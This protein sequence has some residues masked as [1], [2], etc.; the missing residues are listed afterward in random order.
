MA[1]ISKIRKNSW[2]LIVVIGLALAA[3][4]LMDMSSNSSRMSAKDQFTLGTVNGQT[5]DYREFQN[6]ENVLYSNGSGDIYGQRNYL[7]NYVKNKAI[8]NGE[9][10]VLGLGVG[11]PEL[12]E[13]Q[14]GNNLSPIIT[15][16]Y[17]DE[18]G[19]VSREQ[20]NGIR[21]AIQNG[22]FEPQ[23]KQFWAVQEQE[24]I[25]ERVQKK[26]QDMVSK[27][28][29]TPTWLAEWS[30][31]LKTATVDMEYVKVPYT[32]VQDSEIS[33]SDADLTTYLNN[34]KENY[35][36]TKPTRVAEYVTFDVVPTKKDSQDI[37]DNL[38]DLK[39]QFADAENDSTFI[40]L[41]DG[42][43]TEKYLTKD[44]LTPATTSFID[45]DVN[46][47]VG[48]YKED[49]QYRVAKIVDRMMI[50]DSVEVRHIL[51][52]A[53]TQQEAIAA[54]GLV[55]SLKKEIESGRLTFA[56]AATAFG[57]DA[58]KTT[59]GDLGYTSQGRM[60][61]EF[62]DA[63]FFK[64][65]KG[66]LMKVFTQYGI[67]LVE[68]TGQKYETKKE[69]VKFY[70][71]S[72]D[73]IPSITTQNT[74][75]DRIS[76]MIIAAKSF[77]DVRQAVQAEGKAVQRSTALTANDFNFPGLGSGQTAR[78]IVRWMFE[79]GNQVGTVAPEVFQ[80]R[81]A[82]KFFNEKYIL[83]GLASI[84][85]GEYS[86]IATVSDVIRPLVIN[87]KKAEKIKG[88]VSTADL[89]SATSTFGVEKQS[90]QGVKLGSSFIPNLGNEPGV[91]GALIGANTGDVIGP[92]EGKE[93]VYYVKVTNKS[94]ATPISNLAQ[95]KS[96]NAS[97][98]K[99]QTSFRLMQSLENAAEIEDKRYN[100]Y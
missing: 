44:Q 45:L 29:Y 46:T 23:Q 42:F 55:D 71:V 66:E 31:E 97:L 16:R 17:K 62:N 72:E 77:D 86:T 35:R 36:L 20:L 69:G 6:L 1:L 39:N 64:A 88:Q 28:I 79:P 10:E 94:A 18:Q 27:A 34:N 15:Q 12:T 38:V 9:A 4:I 78:D 51:R 80:F 50:A 57:T 53:K 5:L 85:E 21:G 83:A 25:A 76:N 74:E 58:T 75:L 30:N 14:W 63:I 37:Y 40:V 89:N 13:L 92:I 22:T 2:L 33:L 52:P 99:N 32:Q 60:V 48:P 49:G 67:H 96:L 90:A 81:N 26:L 95:A 3:F 98:T 65:K 56:D 91:V 84:D 43:Y 24:I 82:E 93:G 100:F 87:Q 41:E 7:W 19:R 8:A 68:V 70:Y 47:L 11:I 61:A 73:I 54:I 59:G